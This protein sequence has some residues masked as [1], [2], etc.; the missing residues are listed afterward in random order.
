M[1]RIEKSMQGTNE[2]EG[3]NGNASKAFPPE[4]SA[5]EGGHKTG[6]YRILRHLFPH[7][8]RRLLVEHDALEEMHDALEKMRSEVQWLRDRL[9]RSLLLQGRLATQSI[10]KGRPLP[11]LADAEFRVF[12]QWGED[13]IIEWLTTQITVPNNRFIEFGVENFTEAN[14][15]YLMQNRN[16]KGLIFDGNEDYMTGL[17]KDRLFWMYDLTAKAAFITAENIND[18]ISEAGFAGPL[19]ILSIDIDGNDYW[20]WRAITVVDPAIVICEFNPFL[21]DQHAV[22]VPYEP[23]FNRFKHHYSGLY[24]GASIAALKH[25]AEQKGYTFVGTNSSGINAFFVRRDL[26]GPVLSQLQEVRAFC[27]RVRGSRDENGE[28]SFVGGQARL[29]LIRNCPFVEVK[30][31]ATLLLDE[32]SEPYSSSWKQ[33]ID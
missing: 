29:D 32:M 20:I 3:Q 17:R 2:A 28:L 23:Q 11:T 26:A 10:T 18:L 16:W 8:V 7:K 30:T 19:G 31:G 24:F 12:S 33:D 1:T 4:S 27:S 6:W 15:R 9:E 14:C 21:G 5:G 22:T 13:G 25:L